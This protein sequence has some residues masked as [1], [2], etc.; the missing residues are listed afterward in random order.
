MNERNT[1]R[2]IS[3]AKDARPSRWGRNTERDDDEKRP[4]VVTQDGLRTA[5]VSD[6]DAIQALFL[7]AAG[8]DS[9]Q[10]TTVPAASKS[11]HRTKRS[12]Q[13]TSDRNG[14]KS[15]SSL[16]RSRSKEDSYYGPASSSAPNEDETEGDVEEK[17]KPDFG[18][19]GA[20]VG[21]AGAV[22]GTPYKGV[23]LK[24]QEPPEARTP[25]TQWRLY[26]F[27]DDTEIATLHISKQSA[28]LLGRNA[29]IADIH[30]EHPSIS[31]QHAVLQ[32]RAM[33]S[34]DKGALPCQPYLMDLESTN[35]SFLNGVRIDTARY[36]Q[37]RKGDVLR[38]GSSTREY[39]LL[40]A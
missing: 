35:G 22:G 38:F 37:L 15:S 20:L 10:T 31:S 8:R 19:S 40:A 24:F 6:P 34:G 21:T 9:V 4:S 14:D 3:N 33:P 12:L 39:V 27:K 16:K 2:T 36:Y 13:D 5:G 11:V 23:V 25:N 28:Y 17:Q 30:L 1:N 29:D 18:L 32:Y 7:E 26:V